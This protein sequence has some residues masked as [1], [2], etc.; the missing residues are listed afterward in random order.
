[1][2]IEKRKKL[3]KMTIRLC[4]DLTELMEELRGSEKVNP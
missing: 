2:E 4:K 3:A 1:M